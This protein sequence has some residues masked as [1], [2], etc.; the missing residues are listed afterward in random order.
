MGR[1][2]VSKKKKRFWGVLELFL[3]VKKV[4]KFVLIKDSDKNGGL[5]ACWDRF[6]FGCKTLKGVFQNNIPTSSIMMLKKPPLKSSFFI[7]S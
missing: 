7:L 1:F 4:L 3:I 6:G 2:V 5:I